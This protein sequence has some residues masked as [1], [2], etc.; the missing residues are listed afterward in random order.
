MQEI[1][2]TALVGIMAQVALHI[3]VITAQETDQILNQS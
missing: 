1:T 3:Y 2:T